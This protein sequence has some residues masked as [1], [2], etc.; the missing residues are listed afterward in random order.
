MTFESDRN[1]NDKKGQTF[2]RDWGGTKG[3]VQWRK[4]SR[5]DFFGDPLPFT[6]ISPTEIEKW[7]E[8]VLS[9]DVM[10]AGFLRDRQN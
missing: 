8:I 4:R 6:M 9:F 5:F 7:R 3:V 10:K 2:G 1:V